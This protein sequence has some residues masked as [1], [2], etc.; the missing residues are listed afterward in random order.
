MT[1]IVDVRTTNEFNSG[2]VEVALNVPLDQLAQRLSHEHCQLNRQDRI[3]LYCASGARANV[4][5]HLLER[6]GFKDVIN[7]GGYQQIKRQLA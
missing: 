5:K 1:T 6:A 2:H 3:V 4:A 7:A